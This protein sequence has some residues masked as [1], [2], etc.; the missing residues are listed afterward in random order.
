MMERD[1]ANTIVASAPFVRE[2]DA[3]QYG[4]GAGSVHLRC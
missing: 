1:R 4:I 2:I 3:I